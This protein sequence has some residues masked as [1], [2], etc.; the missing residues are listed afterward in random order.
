M[1]PLLALVLT[2]LFIGCLFYR[3]RLRGYTPSLA[4]CVPVV[5]MFILGSRTVTEWMHLGTRLDSINARSLEGSALD[6]GVYAVLM[7]SGIL[8]LM[9]RNVPW[10]SLFLNNWAL[11]LF[12]FYCGIS[13]LWS[14]FPFVSFKR[15]L[16]AFGDPIMALIILTDRDPLRATEIV[17]R[18]CANT[19]IPLS[20]LF[21]KYYPHL[22]RIYS[23]WNGAA[24]YTG[25]TTNK[26]LLGFVLMA[27]GLS[28]VWRLY[29]RKGEWATNKID[30]L[31]IPICLLGMVF[32]LFKMADSKTSLIG[33][34]LGA[35]VF[36]ILGS[37]AIRKYLGTYVVAGAIL[38][39]V[40][41]VSFNITEFVIASAGKDA[42]LTGRVEL[43][44]IV[45]GMQKEPA[46]G[47][48]FESFWLGAHID[49]FEDLWYFIPTQA[50]NGYIE[51]YLN[52]GWVGLALFSLVIVSAYMRLQSL[53]RVA[54][55]NEE[56]VLWGR[57]GFAFV[58]VFL[59]YNYTE[60][61]F[62]SPHFLFVI[63]L[64]FAIHR[65]IP[66]PNL[67]V[68]L[69]SEWSSIAGRFPIRRNPVC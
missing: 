43:W 15:W 47:H 32:W 2:I 10:A 57:L 21:I 65:T 1:P 12:L 69:E 35:L 30:N 59:I 54:S 16:K 39:T 46:L 8:I 56:W 49:A 66:S 23:E 19:L 41:Q 42:T 67:V 4:L 52:L 20:I 50:H 3:D 24:A 63:F 13:I 55:K 45:L 18:A 17:F 61:A 58:I 6:A 29:R 60:A 9:K 14:D 27:C 44:E 33:Y 36:V 28:L 22:G 40:L 38:F 51:M 37:R 34:L 25:V 11:V 48:G 68:S 53:L 7:V 64:L 62:K 26:N 5:W 31:V